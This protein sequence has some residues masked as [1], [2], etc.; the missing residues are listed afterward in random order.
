MR[1]SREF[2]QCIDEAELRE[3][4]LY[5][6][7][8]TWWNGR[9]GEQAIWKRLDR[10]FVN[11]QWE[12]E[13]QTHVQ[14]LSKGTSD[15][16]PLLIKLE[17]QRRLG[18]KPFTFLNVWCDHE[19]FMGVVKRSWEEGVDGNAMYTFMTKLKRL[20]AV[21]KRWNWEVFGDIFAKIKKLEGMVREVECEM[22]D[23]PSEENVIKYR[24]AQAELQKQIVIEEKYWQ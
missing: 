20:R 3:V 23:C 13:L 21:L 18:R 2:Q 12:T 16:S 22:Q 4:T 9:N 7:V 6:S 5:G 11:E 15:H 14:H 17:P 24:K 1:K 10:C 19:K 8:F